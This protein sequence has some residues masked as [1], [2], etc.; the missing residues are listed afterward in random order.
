MGD[1][2]YGDPSRNDDL[3]V[4]ALEILVILKLLGEYYFLLRLVA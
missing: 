1:R 4:D 3:D 2:S